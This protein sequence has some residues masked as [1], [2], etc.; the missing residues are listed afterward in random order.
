MEPVQAIFFDLDET[1]LDDNTSYFRSISLASDE[2]ASAFP[3]FDFGRLFGAYRTHSAACWVEMEEAVLQ[4]SVDGQTVRLEGWRRALHDCGCDDA[5]LAG[6]ALE[7]Y[8]RHRRETYA[9]FED[10]RDLLG[11]IEGRLPLALITNGSTDTQWEKARCTGLDTVLQAVVVSGEHGVA[12]PHPDIFKI[13]L[14]RLGVAPESAWHIGDSLSADVAG[15]KAAGLGA[16]VWLNRNGAVR[17]AAEPQPDL[18]I[19]SLTELLDHIA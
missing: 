11:R 18:E 15:A 14:D 16:A 13:A 17:T 3:S 2:L 5:A 19:A 7:A 4:G 8:S 6:I 1:L 10:A 9:L 12:K